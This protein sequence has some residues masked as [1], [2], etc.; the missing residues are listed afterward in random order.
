MEYFQFSHFHILNET[1]WMVWQWLDER[2]LRVALASFR[3]LSFAALWSVFWEI[4]FKWPFCSLYYY[5]LHYSERWMFPTFVG[6]YVAHTKCIIQVL[7]IPYWQ[8]FVMNCG[9]R[10]QT[11][12]SLSGPSRRWAK[13]TLCQALQLKRY[14]NRVKINQEA[15]HWQWSVFSVFTVR[16]S[17]HFL[18]QSNQ[19]LE[20]DA[21]AAQ[22]TVNCTLC[23]F[24]LASLL[25]A[26]H[27]WWMEGW[28]SIKLWG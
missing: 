21:I 16:M 2:S 14:E 26:S 23:S 19:W 22:L 7:C 3:S 24:R 1:Q 5:L 27:R 12:D 28:N 4:L 18:P 17:E 6:L 9:V 11:V 25:N 13:V 15:A 10:S 8:R 20:W